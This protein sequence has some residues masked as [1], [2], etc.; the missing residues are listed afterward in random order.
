MR[1]LALGR[2]LV[3]AQPHARDV[4]GAGRIVF[5]HP[6]HGAEPGQERRTVC[7]GELELKAGADLDRLLGADEDAARADVHAVTVD[8]FVQRRALEPDA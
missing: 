6:G 5:A 1:V 8:E 3:E 4:V 7:Q 2:K